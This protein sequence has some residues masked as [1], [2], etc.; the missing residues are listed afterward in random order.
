MQRMYHDE[1]EPTRSPDPRKASQLLEL[2]KHVGGK[3][4]GC[5]PAVSVR[6]PHLSARYFPP[7]SAGV[8]AVC[9]LSY[10]RLFEKYPAASGYPAAE[11]SQ[12]LLFP[13]LSRAATQPC[14]E[15]QP[16]L[17]TYVQLVLLI[18]KISWLARAIAFF[19]G[20][21]RRFLRWSFSLASVGWL[22]RHGHAYVRVRTFCEAAAP[23]SR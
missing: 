11:C 23:A 22:V 6:T 17:H 5:T 13:P 8:C 21:N 15:C 16:F 9:A 20:L 2:P 19:R 4:V 3:A 1:A 14:S 10:N 7:S 12:H 18:F